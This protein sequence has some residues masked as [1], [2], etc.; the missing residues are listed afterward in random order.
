MIEGIEEQRQ[1]I[2]LVEALISDPLREQKKH[3][4]GEHHVLGVCPGMD[5]LCE[6]KFKTF[7]G[8][9]DSVLFTGDAPLD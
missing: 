2:E 3:F 8:E 6:I 4:T 1:K 5:D 9:C 7:Q